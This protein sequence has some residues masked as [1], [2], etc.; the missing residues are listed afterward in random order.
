MSLLSFCT[1]IVVVSL[2]SM[3]GSESLEFIKNIF[4]LCS[5][6]GWRSCGFGTIWGWVINFWV[7][8]PF[9]VSFLVRVRQNNDRQFFGQ[10]CIS[11][12][13]Q[14]VTVFWQNNRYLLTVLVLGRY[15]IWYIYFFDI[16]DES[17]ALMLLIREGWK[18]EILS[19]RDS[20]G[21]TPLNMQEGINLRL[22][23][24]SHLSWTLLTVPESTAVVLRGQHNLLYSLLWRTSEVF[25]RKVES[26]FSS[27]FDWWGLLEVNCAS[28]PLLICIPFKSLSGHGWYLRT[29]VRNEFDGTFSTQFTT[30]SS[31]C[32]LC[33]TL[34]INTLTSSFSLNIELFIHCWYHSATAAVKAWVSPRFIIV[35]QTDDSLCW[36]IRVQQ[37]ASDA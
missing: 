35:I 27:S 23:R 9:K 25:Q 34:S 29:I 13:R 37:R 18:L 22:F 33:L 16:Q 1:L 20:Y 31:S 17:E 4:D 21:E 28:Q 32:F 36:W 7:N 10:N 11:S 2:L 19:S 15:C 5:E 26:P 6:D 14:G 24:T 3:R 8:Y 30:F 12:L